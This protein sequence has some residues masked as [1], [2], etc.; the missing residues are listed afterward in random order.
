ME[1]PTCDG[2]V[3]EYYDPVKACYETRIILFAHD[4]QLGYASLK[5]AIRAIKS[6]GIELQCIYFLN[7]YAQFSSPYKGPMNLEGKTMLQRNLPEEIAQELLNYS[8]PS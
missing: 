7:D 6:T 3:L 2:V 4:A 1:K 5:M 8:P